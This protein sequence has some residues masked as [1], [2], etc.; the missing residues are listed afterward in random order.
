MAAP[1]PAAPLFGSSAA[2]GMN[3]GEDTLLELLLHANEANM[4]ASKRA[5]PSVR[6][7]AWASKRGRQS[8]GVK[9]W[10][11]RMFFAHSIRV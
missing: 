1:L 2:D 11:S 4:C 10:A 9:A 8:V 3:W 7:K 6:V 5:R